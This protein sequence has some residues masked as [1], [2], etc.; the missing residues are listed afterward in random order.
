MK[1]TQA[2]LQKTGGLLTNWRIHTPISGPSRSELQSGKYFHNIQSPNTTTPAM[3]MLGS[4]AVGHVDLGHKVWPHIYSKT[5]REE[6]GYKT[7]LFGKCM[8]GD[9]GP[10]TFSS[11]VNL[12][13]LG[14]TY[15][16]VF[17]PQIPL[18]LWVFL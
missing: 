1:Q 8:N 9:C 15:C 12:H 11:G 18:D 6:K 2:L 14:G 16:S 3:K 13:T 10:N 7:A 4:G 17:D 5:L